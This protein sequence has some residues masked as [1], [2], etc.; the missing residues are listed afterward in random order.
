[1]ATTSI[2]RIFSVMFMIKTDLGSKMSGEWLNDLM[3]CYC[4]KEIYI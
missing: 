4:E 3:I 2:E 1:V